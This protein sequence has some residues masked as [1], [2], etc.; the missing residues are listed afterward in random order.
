[1]EMA[2]KLLNL[3]YNNSDSYVKCGR[4][5]NKRKRIESSKSECM[6]IY[7][8]LGDSILNEIICHLLISNYQNSK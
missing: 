6:E 8:W 7:E 1:M 3:L 5:N 4:K 2:K